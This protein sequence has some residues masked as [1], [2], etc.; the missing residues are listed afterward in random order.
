MPSLSSRM[1][2]FKPSPMIGVVARINELKAQG[3]DIISL[4]AGEPDFDTPDTVKDAAVAA[5]RRGET[6]YTAVDGTP[7]LKQA[8]IE[9]FRRENGLDY[10]PGQVMASAGAKQVIFNA[11]MATLEEGDAVI[12][13]APYW[14]SYPGKI[15]LGDGVPVPVPCGEEHGLKLQPDDLARAITPKTKWVVLNSPNNPSGATYTADELKALAA[16]LLDHDHVWIMCDDIYEHILYDGRTFAT[17][18]QAEPRLFDRTL[19]VNGVSKAYAMTGWRLGYGGGPEELIKAMVKVQSQCTTNANSV[20]QAATIEALNGPQDSVRE[21]TA[22]FQE[23]RDLVVS[24][25]NQAKGLRCRSPEGSFYAYPNCAGVIGRKTPAGDAIG[26]D[27]DFA[28]YLL[29]GEGVAAMAGT[30]FGLSPYIRVSFAASMDE[31]EEA[32]KR[33]QRACAALA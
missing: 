29:E 23:R 15:M 9:K 21:R 5:M 28:G 32:C 33:I 20:S 16:V 17:M 31:L 24:M 26:D 13:P 7:A 25:L 8:I 27:R 11:F 3:R 22:A 14:M 2:R 10:A 18:A 1:G 6:K 4:N 19:T 30:L 12:L